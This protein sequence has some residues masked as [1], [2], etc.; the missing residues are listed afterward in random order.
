MPAQIKAKANTSAQR[1]GGP[2]RQMVTVDGKFATGA[3]L[4]FAHKRARREF[5]AHV[6][7]ADAA[8]KKNPFTYAQLFKLALSEAWGW[9]HAIAG[10]G[11]GEAPAR[12]V[13]MFVEQK[14]A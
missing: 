6:R 10:G 13:A 7:L 9:A 2:H 3:I 5:D 8:G 12:S 4:S 14:A 1:F 11:Q